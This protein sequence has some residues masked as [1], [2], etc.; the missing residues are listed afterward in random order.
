MLT[1]VEHAEGGI[2]AEDSH[3][4]DVASLL[5]RLHQRADGG[6]HACHLKTHLETLVAKELGGRLL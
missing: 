3:H 5:D 6:F 2:F 4:H 1:K